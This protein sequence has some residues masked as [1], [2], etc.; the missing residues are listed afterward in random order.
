MSYGYR[1]RFDDIWPDFRIWTADY[2]E[3]VRVVA[4]AK[5]I[6]LIKESGDQG[7]RRVEFDPY[8]PIGVKLGDFRTVEFQAEAWSWARIVEPF[9]NVFMVPFRKEYRSARSYYMTLNV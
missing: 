1:Y 2:T 6:F 9:R 4:N 7:L 3:V 5:F 8:V